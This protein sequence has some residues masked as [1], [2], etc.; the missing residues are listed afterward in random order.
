M[1][2]HIYE[3]PEDWRE[4]YNPDG[5]TLTGKCCKCGETQKAYG[6]RWMIPKHDESLVR[7]PNKFAPEAIIFE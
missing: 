5:L 1:C 3:F 2:N 7:W 4:N 6:M